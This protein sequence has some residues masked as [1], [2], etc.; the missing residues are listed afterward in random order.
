MHAKNVADAALL[1]GFFL[2]I[3]GLEV[4][5]YTLHPAMVSQNQLIGFS[6]ALMHKY[7]QDHPQKHKALKGSFD[8]WGGVV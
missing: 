8:R 5:S 7:K 4:I 1:G 6:D 2:G 3:E